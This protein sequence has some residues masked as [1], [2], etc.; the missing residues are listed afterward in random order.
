MSREFTREAVMKFLPAILSIQRFSI[1]PNTEKL[2]LKYSLLITHAGMPIWTGTTKGYIF[3]IIDSIESWGV[4]LT[5]FDSKVRKNGQQNTCNLSCNIAAARIELCCAFY[6]PHQTCLA[7][8]QVVNRFEL[9]WLKTRKISILKLIFQQCGKTSC[10]FFHTSNKKWG[11]VITN[12]DNK[13]QKG[14]PSSK[15]YSLIESCATVIY[16]R[17]KN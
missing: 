7:T 10:T 1:W 17:K 9:G 13:L 12:R 5:C 8:N 2:S 3:Q 14:L 16:W 11:F 4:R 15:V 6:N